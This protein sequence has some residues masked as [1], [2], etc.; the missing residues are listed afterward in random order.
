[1]TDALAGVVD[2]GMVSREIYPEELDKGAFWVS[3]ARDAVFITVN[4]LNPVVDALRNQGINQEILYGIYVTSEITTWGQV[5]GKLEV[6]DPVHV[7]TRSDAAG[8]PATFA[9]YLYRSSQVNLSLLIYSLDPWV[10]LIVSAKDLKRLH[11]LT[12]EVF[13]LSKHAGH[14]LIVA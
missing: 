13:L 12:I 1:M 5:V 2:I 7:Y 4:S 14:N 3:V 9:E 8:A 10:L 11:S 6:Q